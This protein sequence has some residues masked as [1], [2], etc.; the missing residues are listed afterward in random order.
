MKATTKLSTLLI[1]AAVLSLSGCGK[2]DGWFSGKSDKG[3]VQEI[4]AEQSD[5]TVAM[6]L[7]DFTQLVER[8]GQAVVNIQAIRTVSNPNAGQPEVNPFPEGDPFYDFFRRLIPNMPDAPTAEEDAMNF[9]S[10]F[11]I[12]K[13]GYILTNTHVVSGSQQIK[14]MLNDKREYSAKLIGQDLQSDVSLLKIEAEDLPVV[15]IGNPAELKV[16]E[17][18]AAIGAP[19]GFDNSVTSGIVSAK[20]RSLPNENYTPFI[21]TDVA[22]NPGN[23][24][25]PLFNL[26][27]Q[28]IGINSQIY[29]RSGGFMGISF[30]IPI[31]IAMNVAEQIK[32]TGKVHRGQLGIMVQEVS[33]DLAKSFGLDKPR[34]AL[35]AKVLPDSAAAAAKLKVGDI[36][37]GV[38]ER[39]IE[40]SSDLPVMVGMIPP[41]QKIKLII[42]RAGKSVET[43]VVL[44]DS[45]SAANPHTAQSPDAK[46]QAS[47]PFSIDA[48]GLTLSTLTVEQKQRLGTATGVIVTNAQGWARSAGLMEGDIILQLG[49]TEVDTEQQVRAAIE[50]GDNPLPVFIRRGPSTLFL[51][52][53]TK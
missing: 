42:W 8:E 12:S 21:Q 18:V 20:G 48:I 44:S 9:G 46:A 53:R 38:N 31:D 1:T 28:V 32:T 4:T 51:P 45:A 37:L 47:V 22:I 2:E 27:G 36:I 41:G 16:G 11:I 34:G 52:L 43:T 26:K 35:V 14:V 17:W 13:D 7:P 19:F 49:T 10:G 40:S 3:F 5:G 24:G 33:Y 23:S 30:A 39:Q 6:L 15:S 25:G 50:S 29:S